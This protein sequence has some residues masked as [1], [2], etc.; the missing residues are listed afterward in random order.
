MYLE[1]LAESE[2]YITLQKQKPLIVS[3]TTFG[4]EGTF[5]LMMSEVCIISTNKFRVV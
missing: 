4:G 1:E 2:T 5:L 3:Y